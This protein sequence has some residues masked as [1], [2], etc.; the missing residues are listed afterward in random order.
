M[1]ASPSTGRRPPPWRSSPFPNRTL[2]LPGIA[3][4]TLNRQT[5]AGEGML[6]VAAIYVTRV[7]S[8]QTLAIGTSVC[9]AADLVPVPILPG[10]TLEI[11][12]GGLGVV[13]LGG[14]GYRDRR[15]NRGSKA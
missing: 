14:L 6:T 8:T 3:T 2:T 9:N 12:L 7:G 10:K 5:H 1:D 4:V 11:S 13:L 15:R